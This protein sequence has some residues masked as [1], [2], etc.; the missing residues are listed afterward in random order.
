MLPGGLADVLAAV[1]PP[2]GLAERVAR[3][4]AA[5]RAHGGAG[6]PLFRDDHDRLAYALVRMPATAVAVAHALDA[7]GIGAVAS[8]L[9]LGAGTGAAV[10]AVRDRLAPGATAV[11]VDRDP[12]LLALAARLL[13]AV[14]AALDAR[15]G[16]LAAPPP[17]RWDL[18]TIAYALGELPPE[19]LAAA[20]DA[21]WARSGGC[22]AVVEPGT[23]R[24][25]A[26]IA[27]VRAR[28]L[29]HGAFLRAPCPHHGP[30]PL[31]G[32][33]WCHVGLRVPRSRLH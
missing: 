3:L 31:A 9:D 24:G 21:A 5:Y 7:A 23:P 33:D 14:D 2:P 28:L 25:A 4:T 26:T 20:V 27:A 30:C 29:V 10:W 18:V 11:A 19:R 13:A 12:G 8:H 22:L 15:S 32:G 16:D 6:G 17:G 1:D